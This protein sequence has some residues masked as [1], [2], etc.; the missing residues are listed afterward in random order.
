M[1][2]SVHVLYVIDSLIPGGAE[3]SL[4]ALAPQLVS[5]GVLLDVAYLH[6]R[7]GLQRELEA[8]GA[9]LFC[10][11]G[12]GGRAGWLWRVR[13]LAAARRPDL[14]HT[15]LFEADVAGRTAGWSRRLPV[16]S[17][18]VNVAYGVEQA[19]QG[20]PGWKLRGAQL[21][22][23]LT[24]RSVTRFHAVSR[25][26][27]EQMARRLRIPSGRIEV[28]PR[29]RDAT[30]LGRRTPERRRAARA[31]LGLDQDA[32]VLLAAARHEAQKGLETLVEAVARVLMV[33][34]EA[35]LLVAGRDGAQTARLHADVQRL[36]L[37]HAVRFLGT[38]DD[39]PELMC[40]TDV[41]VLPSRWEGLPG[42]VLE[43]MA[44]ETPV[45]ASD[46]PMVREAV[47]EET[48]RLVPVDRPPLLADAIL[49]VLGDQAEA[50]ARAGRA[51]ADFLQ[52]FTIERS[53]D[54]M[55][56][57]YRRALA[58]RPTPVSDA[59]RPSSRS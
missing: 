14:V 25:H 5:R 6:R 46:L 3:R 19:G 8:A 11:A 7:P 59:H 29:G 27:A 20:V 34:P 23:A 16:V 9:E 12:P 45:V 18:L 53:A 48:A 44:L 39:V 33:E 58:S 15:T 47:T 52:R 54:R 38:R 32:P 4:V 35:R 55:V 49:E 36:Q 2:C 1:M 13:Q 42:T 43:A 56:G 10:L 24:A 57:L 21:L 31:A 30:L 17:S 50:V 41:F 28:V 40:A 22:D 51:R 26:V 37:G